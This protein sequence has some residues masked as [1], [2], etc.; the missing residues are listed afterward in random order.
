MAKF[1]VIDGA[2]GSGKKT[3]F[4]I[5]EA[6]FKRMGVNFRTADFPQYGNPSSF[7]VEKY[8]NGKYGDP[9]VLGAHLPSIFYALDRFDDSARLKQIIA[10]K[11]I[12]LLIS[13]R[14]VSA[15]CGHQGGKIADEVER[16]KYLDWLFDL[17][18]NILKIPKPDLT[19]FLHVP[20][21]IA[22]SLVDKKDARQYIGGKKR[23][24]HEADLTHLQD[25]ISAFKYCAHKFNDW[26]QIDCFVDGKLLSEGEVHE[27]IWEI[28]KQYV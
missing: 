27:K 10:D 8:L 21:D 23:D 16:Q 26:R 15:N 25:A 22:Q 2:D 18:Y 4:D 17:E 14:Y 5:L 9:R 7:F 24:V 3:Q 6:R 1:I 19:I 11:S 12:T 20:A 13:N 28:V